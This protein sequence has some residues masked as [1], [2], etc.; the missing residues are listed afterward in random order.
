MHIQ[1]PPSVSFQTGEKGMHYHFMTRCGKGQEANHC[2]TERLMPD[3]RES[4]SLSSS[5]TPSEV[6]PLPR[7]T[8]STGIQAVKTRRH[9]SDLSASERFYLDYQKKNMSNYHYGLNT[10]SRGFI[11]KFLIDSAL[12]SD[13]LLQAVVAFAA[14]HY[15]VRHDGNLQDFL[16]PYSEALSL[17]RKSLGSGK[18]PDVAD[19]LTML[20]LSSLEVGD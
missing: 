15:A 12:N 18:P 5:V 17:L 20:Q 1:T 10:D 6:E 16:K 7:P 11:H 13:A 14:Y 3:S 2:H 19:L 4:S 9:K 8:L